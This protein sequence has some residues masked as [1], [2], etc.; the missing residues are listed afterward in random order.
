MR[1]L[2]WFLVFILALIMEL[3]LP[4]I[5]IAPLGSIRPQNNPCQIIEQ[6]QI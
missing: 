5:L 3:S 6:I 4:V 1:E 2:L